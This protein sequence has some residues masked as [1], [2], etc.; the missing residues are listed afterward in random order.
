MNKVDLENITCS[1][2]YRQ[3]KKIKKKH[4]LGKGSYLVI[5]KDLLKDIKNSKGL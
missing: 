4:K 5:D 2:I 3:I 1:D